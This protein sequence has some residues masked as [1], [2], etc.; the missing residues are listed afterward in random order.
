MLLP[1]APKNNEVEEDTDPREELVKKLLEY[2]AFKKLSLVLKERLNINEKA[3]CKDSSLA[4][5]IIDSFALPDKLSIELLIDK[6]QTL[7]KRRESYDNRN[8]GKIYRDNFTVEEKISHILSILATADIL[9]FDDLLINCISKLEAIM[10][11]LA[12][13][14]LIKRRKIY[15]EQSGNFDKIVV[16]R[17]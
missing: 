12:I 15:V 1:K 10:T 8:F 11:F 6:F 5:E 14:E 2:K 9:Y 3:L 17:R 7:M 13:L 4:D 16:R